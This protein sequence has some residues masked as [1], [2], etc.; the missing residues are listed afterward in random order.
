MLEDQKTWQLK[1]KTTIRFLCGFLIIVIL[2]AIYNIKQGPKIVQYFNNEELKGIIT[3][4][5]SS[6]GGARIKLNN[7][8]EKH[9]VFTDYN[10]DLR[11]FFD[12]FAQLGDSLYK[13]PNDSYVHLFRNG[14]E[15]T[16]RTKKTKD[17][18]H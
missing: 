6:K 7:K 3:Y 1:R 17:S 18:L 8:S 16:F 10:N 2:F 9:F 4:I 5:Y 11:S 15:Y 13:K 12:E 14:R